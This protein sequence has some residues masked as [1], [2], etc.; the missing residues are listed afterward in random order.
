M[1]KMVMEEGRLVGAVTMFNGKVKREVGDV[2]VERFCMSE[3][4]RLGIL[5]EWFGVRLTGEEERGIRGLV[6]ELKG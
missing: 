1:A 5:R 4:D 2:V 6:T 3:E